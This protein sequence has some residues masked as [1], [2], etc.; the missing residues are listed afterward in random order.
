MR[1]SSVYIYIYIYINLKHVSNTQNLPYEIPALTRGTIQTN[2]TRK[3]LYKNLLLSHLFIARI[4]RKTRT[5][6]CMMHPFYQVPK[7]LRSMARPKASSWATNLETPSVDGW[8]DGWMDGGME[9]G[10]FICPKVPVH[11]ICTPVYIS[12]YLCR[13]WFLS[14]LILFAFLNICTYC[15]VNTAAEDSA[16]TDMHWTELIAT[17]L[18]Q[19]PYI[20]NIFHDVSF[21]RKF[22]FVNT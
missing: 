14:L 12:L 13:M 5:N 8:M 19:T 11:Y 6:D 16:Q 1:R 2:R 15:H 22:L 21:P 4:N 7:R 9:G 10:W 3:K 18:D 20:F 17:N